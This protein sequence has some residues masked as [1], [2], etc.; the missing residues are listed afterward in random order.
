MD[1]T[2]HEE[3]LRPVESAALL[4][5]LPPERVDPELR[6]A[7]RRHLAAAG[8]CVVAVD[9]D[10]LGT[11]S[12][13]GVT[14]MTRWDAQD[15]SKAL[16]AGDPALFLTTNSRGLPPA[17]AEAIN[18]SVGADLARAAG[19]HP[20]LVSRSDST[21]RGHFPGEM[22]A[23]RAAWEAATGEAFD[24]ICLVPSFP[25]AG[26]LTIGDV[27]WVAEGGMLFPAAQTPYAR[28]PA[29]AYR[30]SHL[31]RW[32][33]EKTGG[34][35]RA[36]DVASI[37]LETI[38]QGGPEAFAE[39]LAAVTGGRHVVVNAASY[40]DLDVFAAGVRL[41]EAAGR[42]FFFRSAAPL[43]KALA[44][45]PDAPLLR[46]RELAAGRPSGG[47]LV[48]FGSHV[49]RSTAQLRNARALAGLHAEE[50]RVAAVLE[51]AAREGEVARVAAAANTALARG[52]DALVFTSREVA[53]AAGRAE[54]LAIA[55]SVSAA[56][57]AVVA[58]IERDPRFL[59]GKGG[60][61]S[62]DLATEALG[63]RSARV[64][65]Q[66]LPGVPVWRPGP[67]SRWPGIPFVVFPGNSG[68]DEAVAEVVRGMRGEVRSEE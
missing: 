20:V 27:Q 12:V 68:T 41:A 4:A 52:E 28:D 55:R 49:P 43:V 67:E 60:I 2:R 8:R 63:V 22:E 25:E 30:H 5:A 24:A 11:Q 3:A 39:Q 65:G 17:D 14:V 36:Q 57:A 19:P 33:E 32:V 50:L 38:R 47:G 1:P 6:A 21:L 54:S 46:P 45:I 26:R 37:S 9:D 13:H 51:P 44:G 42:R 58:R 16:A 53:A 59:L 18:R 40:A 48:L 35:V 10:P 23:L 29:F 31:P 15:L 56:M 62:S 61:T 34:R 66:V 7:A 64:L